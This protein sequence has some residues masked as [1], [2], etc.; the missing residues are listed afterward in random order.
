MLA[1]RAGLGAAA[2][3]GLGGFGA[4]AGRAERALG[5]VRRVQPGLFSVSWRGGR[6]R[7]GSA[8]H[9]SSPKSLTQITTDCGESYAPT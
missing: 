7:D 3:A 8:E 5:E 6:R 2:G 4:A 1:C 9:A